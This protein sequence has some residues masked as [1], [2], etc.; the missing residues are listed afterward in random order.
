MRKSLVILAAM[1]SFV[2]LTAKADVQQPI[3]NCAL[4]FQADG[5]G[6]QFLVGAFKLSGPCQIRCLDIAGN[7]QDLDV[8]V[9]MASGP[10]APNIAIGE[11]EMLGL[12]SG[13]GVAK[14]PE[15]LLGKYLTA[16]A[17]V[18]VVVGVGANVAFHGG[19]EALTLNVGMNLVK[20][21]GL[22]AGF[23][24]VKIEKAK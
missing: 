5:G 1:L 23:N 21:F 10:I 15:A 4:T 9:T 20:G 6:L 3:W 8:K 2:G 17:D 22:Q 14:G 18:A 7:H 24:Q 12:A 16:S 19:A 11:F 13:I